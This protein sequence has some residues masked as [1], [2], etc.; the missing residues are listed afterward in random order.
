MA[1]AAVRL[2]GTSNSHNAWVLRDFL[3]RSVV[4][5]DWIELANDDDAQ[6]HLQMAHLDNIRLPVI[7]LPGHGRLFDPPLNE[8]ANRLG[9]STQP[10]LKEYDLLIVGAGPAGLSAGVYAASEGLRTILIEKHSIGGQ[11]GSSSLIENYL[12]FP[13][14]F[15]GT[16]LAEKGRLQ[17]LKFGA[18]FL[19]M[20]EGMETSYDNLLQLS[21]GNGMQLRS[22][23]AIFATGVNWRKL[24]LPDEQRFLGAG[25]YYGAGL[26]ESHMCE[27]NHVIVVGG[28][29]SAGQ[30][31][32][33]LA[34]HAAKVTMLIR[35]P[36]LSG[37]MSMYLIER[38]KA[39][40]NVELVYNAEITELSGN[41]CLE[42]V[43]IKDNE[44]GK[45]DWVPVKCVFACIGGSPNNEWAVKAGIRMDVA[46]YIKTGNDV[47]DEEGLPDDWN[48]NGDRMPMYLES[49]RAGIF[50]VGDI[51]SG[52]IKRMVSAAGEGA[53][54]IS[55]VHNFIRN[56]G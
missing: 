20:Q 45:T 6:K 15:S 50:A 33:H 12:G 41:K 9:W 54:A 17:A 40:E 56:G 32:M 47:L 16:E 10:R 36:S 22:K 53:M 28:G 49:S 25:L 43:A 31:V 52:S 44:T 37:S 39:K 3:Q 26:S 2:Y 46:G 30:A 55:M 24:N 48:G 5:F 29:N 23:T 4:K 14:G 1:K 34:D 42:K 35:G 18:E 19:M 11:A 27:G 38:L 13:K 7:E 21:L 51:R 8:V